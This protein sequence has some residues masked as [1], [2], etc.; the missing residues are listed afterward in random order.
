MANRKKR[1][2]SQQGSTSAGPDRDDK[3]ELVGVVEESLPGTWFKVKID[4]TGA[5]VLAT[6]AG[7]MRQGHIMVLPGD[8]V[9][10]AVSPYDLTR[11]RLCWRH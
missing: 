10:V 9:T 11:G 6:L 2:S 7:K 3:I 5:L 8:R 1:T 4:D